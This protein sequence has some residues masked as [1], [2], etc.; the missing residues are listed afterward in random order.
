MGGTVTEI[1]PNAKK[2][3]NVKWDGG[4]LHAWTKCEIQAISGEGPVKIYGSPTPDPPCE[5]KSSSCHSVYP[6][7]PPPPRGSVRRR[8]AQRELSSPGPALRR[9]RCSASWKR[10]GTP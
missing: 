10:S 7:L 3:V 6:T 4:K 8:M 5:T 1:N 9:P 2:P